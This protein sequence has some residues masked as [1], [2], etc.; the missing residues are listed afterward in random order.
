MPCL[1][2][3]SL[4][5]HLPISSVLKPKP[6]NPSPGK[7]SIIPQTSGVCLP[8]TT[9]LT[10]N[11]QS[12]SASKGHTGV[13]ST[14]SSASSSSVGRSTDSQPPQPPNVKSRQ[15]AQEPG[16]MSASTDSPSPG[17]SIP[18][19][20][21]DSPTSQRAWGAEEDIVNARR[22]KKWPRT[23]WRPAE[24]RRIATALQAQDVEKRLNGGEEGK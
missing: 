4:F 17:P 21:P 6:S 13:P 23:H 20:W 24:P 16:R 19:T 15:Q 3:V 14:H 8:N 9:L 12:S 7:L 22:D 18:Y 2:W 5:P 1:R 11:H 10:M